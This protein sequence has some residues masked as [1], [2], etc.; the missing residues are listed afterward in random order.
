MRRS[1]STRPQRARPPRLAKLAPRLA[2]MFAQRVTAQS[3]AQRLGLRTETVEVWNQR[4]HTGGVDALGGQQR[5]GRVVRPAR[6]THLQDY[7]LR[8]RLD[9]GPVASGWPDD[10]WTR[11]RVAAIV[12]YELGSAISAKAFSEIMDRLGDHRTPQPT[13]ARKGRLAPGGKDCGQAPLAGQG[14]EGVSRFVAGIVPDAAGRTWASAYLAPL[15]PRAGHLRLL[16]AWVKAGGNTR[17]AAKATGHLRRQAHAII[18]Q[19]L[20]EIEPRRRTWRCAD[21]ARLHLALS[22]A[23]HHGLAPYTPLADES[24]GSYNTFLHLLGDDLVQEWAE[25]LLAPFLNSA[26]AQPET[27]A[28]DA[29]LGHLSPTPA[30][31]GL[32][33]WIDADRRLL[34][35]AR[36]LRL[37]LQ[38]FAGLLVDNKTAYA[39]LNAG[40]V[41]SAYAHALAIIAL[42]AHSQDVPW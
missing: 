31:L 21:R 35:T 14:Q 42:T 38:Q 23:D 17:L 2:A 22:I 39:R 15:V 11:E 36:S 16:A 10:M 5:G 19:A 25:H 29:L 33:A 24:A 34:R 40:D 12:R 13:T 30:L 8:H 4:W 18:A 41:D 7:V 28:A 6:L 27:S 26:D 1:D 37:S 20:S 3:V 32:A 9:L